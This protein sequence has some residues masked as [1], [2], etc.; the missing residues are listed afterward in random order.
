MEEYLRV[1]ID[2]AGTGDDGP[3]EK[4]LQHPNVSVEDDDLYKVLHDAADRG[5]A[6]LLKALSVFRLAELT[7]DDDGG[8]TALHIASGYLDAEAV[9]EILLSAGSD[10]HAKD[11]DGRTPLHLAARFGHIAP[12]RRPMRG[13]KTRMVPKHYTSQQRGAM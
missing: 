9:V 7:N 13:L 10:M 11:E 6:E 8:M 4:F 1:T 12:L 3:I 2:L 5:Y